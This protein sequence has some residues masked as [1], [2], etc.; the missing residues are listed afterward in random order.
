MTVMLNSCHFVSALW[1]Y[2]KNFAVK[3]TA[4]IFLYFCDKLTAEMGTGSG[5]FWKPSLDTMEKQEF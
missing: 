2:H 1:L 4:F 5:G 3:L